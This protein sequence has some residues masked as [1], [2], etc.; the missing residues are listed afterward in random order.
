MAGRHAR[1]Q[2]E[3]DLALHRIDVQRDAPRPRADPDRY[4]APD[5]I[6][7]CD[8]LSGIPECQYSIHLAPPA[9]LMWRQEIEKCARKTIRQHW[10]SSDDAR[11]G[12]RDVAN[13]AGRDVDLGGLVIDEV[14]K[15]AGRGSL[16]QTVGTEIFVCGSEN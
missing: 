2:N 8:R 15:R 4:L 7:R 1:G 14:D 10:S 6:R 9:N 13:R 12:E 3:L 11:F 16:S 5:L